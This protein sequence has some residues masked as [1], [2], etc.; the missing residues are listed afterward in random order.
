MNLK[1]RKTALKIGLVVLAVIALA[2]GIV[3]PAYA[4]AKTTPVAPPYHMIQGKVSAISAPNFSVVTGNQ[5]TT[6]TTDNNTQYWIIPQGRAQTFVANHLST[7]NRQDRKRGILKPNP[8]VQ[9]KE[10]H[11]PANWRTNLGWL[12]VFD[13]KANFNDIA[14]GDRVIVRADV[15]NLAKQVLI[16]KAPV[17]RTVRGT[18]A[19]VTSTTITINPLTTAA[20]PTPAPVT[21]NWNSNTRFELKGLIQVEVGQF[22]SAVYNSTNMNALLVNVQAT[23]P[24]TPPP[25]NR[26]DE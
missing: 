16:I 18:I 25:V 10:L 5:T 23:A 24:S 8:A 21:L 3:V 14:I 19:A 11:I 6:I 17:D 20:V 22:A 12:E 2:T 15:N 7:D 26:H 9:L 1:T 13:N 4:Q